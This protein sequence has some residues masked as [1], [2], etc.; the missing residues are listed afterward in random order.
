MAV[1]P[2]SA[3]VPTATPT[4]NV[5]TPYQRLTPGTAPNLPEVRIN[6]AP[7]QFKQEAGSE[8]QQAGGTL[9][10]MSEH[11][12]EIAAD[13]VYN[14]YQDQANK[15][16]HGDPNNPNPDGSPD[17]G[18]LGLKGKKALDERANYEKKLDDLRTKAK[19][20]LLSPDSSLR[21]DTASRRF[22]AVAS[23]QMG[24]HADTQ[25]NAYAMGTYQNEIKLNLD[26]IGTNPDDANLVKSYGAAVVDAHIKLA[27]L[28]GAQPGDPMFEGAKQ[29]GLKQ[30]AKAHVLAVAATDPLRAQRMIEGYRKELGTDYHLL[31]DHVR[32]RADEAIGEGFSHNAVAAATAA[33]YTPLEGGQPITKDAM[34]AAVIGHESG[35]RQFNEKGGVLTSVDNAQGV[36]QI[37][38]GTFALF[39]K[40]GESIVNKADNARVSKRITDYYMD[41]YNG[42]WARTAVAYF[43]G[44]KNVSPPGAPLPWVVDRKDGLG[45]TVSAYVADKGRRLGAIDPVKAKAQAFESVETSNMTDKQK[46]IAERNIERRYRASETASLAD[47]KGKKDAD[48]KAAGTYVTRML[49]N[50]DAKMRQEIANDPNLQPHTKLALDDALQKHLKGDVEQVAQAFGDGFWKNR[51][52]IFLPPGDPNRLSDP[53]DILALAGPGKDVSLQGAQALMAT[54][55]AIQ[56]DVNNHDV[57]QAK[58]SVIHGM[59]RRFGIEEGSDAPGYMGTR[60]Y[61]GEDVFRNKFVPM[62]LQAYDREVKGGGD[63]WKFINDPEIP[64]KLADQLYPRHKAEKDKLAAGEGVPAQTKQ[65]VPPAPDDVNADTWNTIVGQPPVLEN[66][67]Q[68]DISKWMGAINF[69]R[70]NPTPE[71]IAEFN[72]KYGNSQL[73]AEE[74]LEQFKRAPAAPLR[75]GNVAPLTPGRP[76]GVTSLLGQ[77]VP[78]RPAVELDTR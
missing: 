41:K 38:P 73:R 53:A 29:E 28:Q 5:P 33:P 24:T 52:R 78:P 44:E 62:Y 36:G 54:A 12:G 72:K 66:G 58:Q 39:A 7:A 2:D 34:S 63:P 32:T 14:Q 15:L 21:F 13:D 30:A 23:S 11:W 37:T 20:V 57:E 68:K 40:P 9:F 65:P 47:A 31:A 17:L 71:N 43:S 74:I 46:D 6:Q 69:L 4:E 76:A 56:K 45:T 3:G 25:G 16:L 70:Q 42:D 35:G 61:A 60:N 75:S 49:T 51:E 1:I 55:S 48:E 10:R 8:L 26:G 64:Q 18:Y 19:G 50:P 27:Q 22:Q 59:M 67:R 77:P